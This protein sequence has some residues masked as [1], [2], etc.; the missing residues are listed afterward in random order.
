MLRRVGTLP[1][2]LEHLDG[3]TTLAV[4]GE[5][6]AADTDAFEAILDVVTKADTDTVIV[7]LTDLEFMD[8]RGIHAMARSRATIQSL[9][10]SFVLRRP[11]QS[12]RR[13]LEVLR[14]DMPVEP[15][16]PPADVGAAEERRRTE[17]E[18]IDKV[19]DLAGTTSEGWEQ[20]IAAVVAGASQSILDLPSGEVS[21]L[22]LHME[23]GSV[24]SYRAKVTISFKDEDD[25][26]LRRPD[27][28]TLARANA[29]L[30]EFLRGDA[31]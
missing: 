16:L 21:R 6:D 5:I 28:E 11:P 2:L 15:N 8:V 9:G 23:N 30:L 31:P 26:R 29:L 13:I 22:D 25:A 1:F 4:E 3:Q 12:V 24:V 10:R 19:I 17:P 7:D 14:P 20:A 18:T 27:E